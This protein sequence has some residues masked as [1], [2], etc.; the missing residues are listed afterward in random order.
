MKLQRILLVLTCTI[1]TINARIGRIKTSDQSDTK[2]A[3]LEPS[4]GDIV[5]SYYD[6]IFQF[7][8]QAL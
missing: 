5:V 6:N 3:N 1:A 8:C 2:D 4:V 7:L